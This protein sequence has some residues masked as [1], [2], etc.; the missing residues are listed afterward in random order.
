MIMTNDNNEVGK[1]LSIE[2][3]RRNNEQEEAS[4]SVGNGQDASDDESPSSL[5]PNSAPQA[6]G[7]HRPQL[8]EENVRFLCCIAETT[9]TRT[10]VM[11]VSLPLRLFQRR[12]LL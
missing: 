7:G 2:S 4:I 11:F 1:H 9:P 8:E 10:H 5:D 6:T 12:S 3:M